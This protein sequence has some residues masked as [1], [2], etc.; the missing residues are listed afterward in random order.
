MDASAIELGRPYGIEPIRDGL[1]RSERVTYRDNGNRSMEGRE[2]LRLLEPILPSFGITRV[3]DISNLAP[4]A[5]PVF[6]SCRPNIFCH[7][8]YGQNT[9]SQGKGRSRTQA[10]ISC[11]MESIESF[12]SEPK[13]VTQIRATYAFLK[14]QF[15][16]MDP[17]E[18]TIRYGGSR[19][20]WSDYLMWTPA[21]SVEHDCEVWIPSETVFMPFGP[22]QF[23]TRSF[24]PCSSNG[25][26]SGATYIESAIHALYEVIERYYMAYFEVGKT[27]ISGLFEDEYEGFD[28][29][30]FNRDLGQEFELQLFSV[31]LN[32]V[33]INI[34]MILCCLAREAGS[35][36]GYGCS[37]NVAMSIDRAISEALQ[38]YAT[39]ISG[40][41][42]DMHNRT[43]LPRKF[44]RGRAPS[45]R[46]LRILDYTSRVANFTFEDLHDEY[47]FLIDWIHQC[48]F[49]NI[50]IAN[51][52]RISLEIPVVK[53]IVP[54]MPCRYEVRRP[55]ETKPY[56]HVIR[57]S[58]RF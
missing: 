6:Q 40:S 36:I 28:I 17:S 15:V 11:I 31:E 55:L 23:E 4:H 24:F 16:V 27:Y 43:I 25:L 8:T 33:A 54:G 53:V 48:G 32:H 30:A 35:Y 42:E 12:C 9:G 13:N 20:K 22:E 57:A 18:F 49:Q 1:A 45:E 34:P 2:F 52:T 50:C 14:K 10:K 21:Y 39:R 58:F 5:F 29:A 41:R 19:P 56:D 51:L 47:R 44:L 38:S 3:A 46:N 26:A 37:G 7:T